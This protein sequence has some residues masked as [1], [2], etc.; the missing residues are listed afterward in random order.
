[1]IS[2]DKKRKGVRS[3][4][5][6][7][8]TLLNGWDPAGLLDAGA[9]RDEYAGLAEDLLAMLTGGATADE[10]SA[11]LNRKVHDDFRVA[12]QGSDAFARKAATWF[13]LSSREEQQ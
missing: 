2:V 6:Q 10:I 3:Q 4:R 8:L 12:P 7:L 5:D 9:R 11:W 13:E 1:V